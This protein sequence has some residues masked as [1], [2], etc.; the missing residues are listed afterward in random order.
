MVT[1]AA[2]WLKEPL[3]HFLL[4]GAAIYASYGLFAPSE[5]AGDERIV[6]ITAGDIESLA[7]NWQ[8]V[9]NRPP[10]ARELDGLVRQYVREIVLYR[11]ALAMGLDKD[12]GV[13]RRRL[14]Q[15]LEFLSRDVTIP[16][17]PES[18]VLEAWFVENQARYREPDRYTI[19]Q[20]YLDPDSREDRIRQDVEA[21]RG[22]LNSIDSLPDNAARYGDPFLLETYYAERTKS[23]LAS[24]FGLEFA[25][26]VTGLEPGRW[27]GPVSSPYGVHLVY[28]NDHRRAPDPEFAD[29]ED[30]VREDWIAAR[31]EELNEQFLDAVV[32]RYE[33]VVEEANVPLTRPRP[34][35]PDSDDAVP[36]ASED[37][38]LEETR[39]GGEASR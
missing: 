38:Q 18:E 20:I 6:T 27:H 21:I 31:H 10:T 1:H 7:S 30:Q 17:A 25:R 5:E 19:T 11:E 33:V 28:V 9:W 23:D 29:L 2:R 15:K 34:T 22:E 3:L 14:G 4:I 36:D 37:A 32:E 26:S 39:Q 35:D 24:L 13:I 16:P 12:D 8:R